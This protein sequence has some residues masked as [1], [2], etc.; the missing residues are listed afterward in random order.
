MV[1]NSQSLRAPQYTQR[2][3]GTSAADLAPSAAHAW[4]CFPRGSGFALLG[5]E[6][7]HDAAPRRSKVV[8]PTRSVV[9]CHLLRETDVVVCF[10]WMPLTTA[11]TPHDV[12]S[13]APLP[14]VH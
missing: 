13:R 1:A 6:L 3:C 12:R 14:E 10:E 2:E 9:M 11:R 7:V 4:P 8:V 5:P